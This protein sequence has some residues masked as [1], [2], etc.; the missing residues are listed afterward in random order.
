MEDLLQVP[1]YALREITTWAILHVM[2]VW[3]YYQ[4]NSLD[5]DHWLPIWIWNLWTF[6]KP[7][8][9]LSEHESIHKVRS[10]QEPAQRKTMTT[11]TLLWLNSQ[12]ERESGSCHCAFQVTSTVYQPVASDSSNTQGQA[13]SVFS[14]HSKTSGAQSRGYTT[15]PHTGLTH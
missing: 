1:L 4:F 3:M 14:C 11:R 7:F 13:I 8:D 6:F 2:L 10:I 12:S 15:Y 5:W 9:S